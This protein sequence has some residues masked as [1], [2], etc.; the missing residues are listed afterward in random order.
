MPDS[1]QVMLVRRAF[2]AFTRRDVEAVLELVAPDFEFTA[3]RTAERTRGGEPYRGRDGIR[4]Y[5]EDVAGVWRE[6]RVIPQQFKREGDRV[7]ALGRVYARD[8]Q[9]SVVDSPAGWVWEVEDELLAYGRVYERPEDAVRA[10]AA[11]AG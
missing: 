11:E 9:G 4:E 8:H 6:L 2:D 1:E 3:P 10:F 5:F 7:L